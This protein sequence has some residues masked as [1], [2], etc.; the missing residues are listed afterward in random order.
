[1]RVIGIL[2]HP[3]RRSKLHRGLLLLLWFAQLFRLLLRRD[4]PWLRGVL[5]SPGRRNKFHIGLLRLLVCSP[6]LI[7]LLLRWDAPGC[8]A[9]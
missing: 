9:F 2:V 6:Q 5:I 8:E 4:A 1:M 3:G 7:R